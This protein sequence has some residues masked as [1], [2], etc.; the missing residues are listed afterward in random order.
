MINLLFAF[1]L[2]LY[3]IQV[4]ILSYGL[5]R[6]RGK[7]VSRTTPFIS[8]VIAARNEE[9]NLSACLD[10]V[11]DQTYPKYEYEIIVVNDH[12]NDRTAEICNSYARRYGNLTIVVPDENTSIRG[13]TNALIY[14]IDSAKGEIIMITDADCIVPRRWIERTVSYYSEEVGIVGGMTIQRANGRFSGMQSLD[15]VYLLGL[16]SAAVNLRNPLSIIG[17]NLSFRRK[18]YD[19]VGGYRKIKFSITEDYALFQAIIQ[20]GNWDYLYP[21]HPD[22]VVQSEPCESLRDLI[23]QKQRWGKGGLDMKISGFYIMAVGF[24]T[25]LSIVISFLTGS[26]AVGSSILFAKI[27]G[28]YAFLHQILKVINRK[29]LIRYFY[30]FQLYYLLYVLLLPMIVFFGGKVIWKGRSF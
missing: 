23:R 7:S 1:I 29:N 6:S 20:T 4:G 12:S 3:L 18:A 25:H 27:I 13:K 22:L 28:D 2:V 26:V 8:V 30:S 19:E 5:S 21:L 17:N 15:W 24:L 10:S 11:I 16:A 14:G 9:N